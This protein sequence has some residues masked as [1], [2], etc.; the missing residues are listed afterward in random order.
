MIRVLSLCLTASMV[1]AGDSL[2]AEP[3]VAEKAELTWNDPA[4]ASAEDPDFSIQGEYG[5][6]AIGQAWAVQVVALRG[7]QFDAYL[8]DRE[9]ATIQQRNDQQAGLRRLHHAPGGSHAL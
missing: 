4:K 9:R 8:P 3:S 6:D 7:G 5:V 1:F 2:S